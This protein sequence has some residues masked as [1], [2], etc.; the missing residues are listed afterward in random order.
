MYNKSNLLIKKIGNHSQR[1]RD[2][3]E[4][5]LRVNETC[6]DELAREQWKIGQDVQRVGD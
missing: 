4:V 2:Q 5:N 1:S 3:R 6:G